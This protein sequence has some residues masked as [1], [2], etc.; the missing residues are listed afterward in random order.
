M[1]SLCSH[2]EQF[3]Q[4]DTRRLLPDIART[5]RNNRTGNRDFARQMMWA[6]R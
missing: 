5:I 3:D 1:K 6:E 4:F 2:M